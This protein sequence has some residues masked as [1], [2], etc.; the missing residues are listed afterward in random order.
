[1]SSRLRENDERV[2]HLLLHFGDLFLNKE[3]YWLVLKLLCIAIQL[4][5]LDT[6]GENET[7]TPL[8]I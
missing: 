7:R 4:V 8:K 1:M 2:F 6:Y 3:L 5:R